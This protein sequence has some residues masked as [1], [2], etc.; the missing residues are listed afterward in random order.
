[1]NAG[2]RILLRLAVPL[3]GV[4][5]GLLVGL[6]IAAPAVSMPLLVSVAA[7]GLIVGGA[8]TYCIARRPRYPGIA[9]PTVGTAETIAASAVPPD[10]TVSTAGL[11][12]VISAKARM[13]TSDLHHYTALAGI[14]R[15]QIGNVSV[16]TEAAALDVLTRL[17]QIDRHVQDMIAFLSRADTS[18][19]MA[20]LMDRTEAR[21]GEN[22]R[23]L[24]DF[25]ESRGQ[26]ADESEERLGQVQQMAADLNR[27]V[28]QVRAISKQT[29]M[30]A[31]NAM[32]EA[33]RAGEAGRG[34]AVV[35]SEVK[36][37]SRDSDQAAVDI[38]GGI[39]RLE[40]AITIDMRTTARTRQEAERVGLGT[41]SE[42]ISELSG[43]LDLLIGHQRDVLA[44]VQA[45][46]EMIAQPI[47][48]LI[49]SIQFQDVTRQQLEH[50][51]QGVEFI[52][53]HSEQLS[54]FLQ[55]LDND[56]DLESAQTGIQE[57]M[58][59]YVMSRE[60]NIHNASIGSAEIED[61]GPMVQ[62]F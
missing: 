21:M 44:K 58:A 36:Q 59:H 9:G 1:M 60:R 48:A 2:R 51:S 4:A 12:D 16:E 41:I 32:I 42:S 10:A 27:V 53:S 52:A 49:G 11:V 20:D 19:K 57:L 29:N 31:M 55:D 33:T 61:R 7:L 35:A 24:D 26:A 3:L 18:D 14:L 5:A 22:R 37:L 46:S 39:T 38:Q 54:V 45:S 28:G 50:V 47:L 8:A 30:L 43:N 23:L 6:V 34:F 17:N 56:Q 13:V 40:N 15:D 62:L 25:R